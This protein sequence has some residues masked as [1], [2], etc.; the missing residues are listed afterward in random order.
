[1]KIFNCSLIFLLL[2]VIGGYGQETMAKENLPNEVLSRFI[3]D[4]AYEM[5]FQKIP[6]DSQHPE[7]MLF[8]IEANNGKVLVKGNTV[9]AQL[10][11]AYT[12]LKETC[13]SMITWSG[14]NTPLPDDWPDFHKKALLPYK[15]ALQDNVTVFGYTT[16]YF[17]WPE[18]QRYL[19]VMAL[20]GYNMMYAPVGM[21]AIWKKVWKQKEITGEELNDYFSGPSFLPWQ[22]M[23][24][25]NKYSGPIP[26]EYFSESLNLQKRILKRMKDLEIT[27]IAPAF[28]GFVPEGFTTQYPDATVRSLKGY[29][30]FEKET[31]S[32]ILDPLSPYFSEIGE[33]FIIE[34]EKE[35]G[36][37]DFFFADTFNENKA[38]VSDQSEELVQQEL[39]QY[40]RAIYSSIA[41]V[42]PEATWVMMAWKFLD[43]EFWSPERVAAFLTDIPD[44][45]ILILDLYAETSP[46]WSRLE[47]FYGKQWMFSI[48]PNWG[49]SNHLGGD[50]TEYVKLISEMKERKNIGNLIAFGYSP[51]GTENNEVVYELASDAVWSDKAIDLDLW[52]ENYTISRYGKKNQVIEKAWQLLAKGVYDREVFH[53]VNAFQSRPDGTSLKVGTAYWRDPYL[54]EALNLFLKNAEEFKDNE[55]FLN[56]LTEIA[57][58][59]FS[60][61]A[62]HHINKLRIWVRQRDFQ[63]ADAEM[64]EVKKLLTGID[65]ILSKHSLY[66][67]ERWVNLA[68]AWGNNEEEKN[69]YEEDAKRIVTY[70]G[71]HLSEYSA[72]L[73]SGLVKNY[74][75]ARWEAWYD[76]QKNG[77]PFNIR[78]WEQEWV[79]TPGNYKS[80]KDK[81]VIATIKE[82]QKLDTE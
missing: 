51:E 65:S 20:H 31:A 59:H 25:I 73:W 72:R 36:K 39:A 48:I 77:E 66:N 28:A 8:E 79:K 54:E 68:R 14:Q 60:V 27:P 67:L 70:W 40:G 1:M 10:R 3:G 74:Y 63:K 37:A 6:A 75:M 46:Q 49:G 82:L 4:R 43:R 52:L 78:A 32:H 71:A 30:E 55:L 56:D 17:K 64:Q 2:S 38:P 18:W 26:E 11:G 9:V 16:P 76:A 53:P 69:Y 29:G 42:K 21:E 47:N 62:D 44:D 35:F 19:D 57:V 80:E 5:V 23:G 34:W 41:Q 24:N 81:D 58:Y 13:N 12:Y 50:L 61:M 45:K 22:R 15:F 7:K 33:D